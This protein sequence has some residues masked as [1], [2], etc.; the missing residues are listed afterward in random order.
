MLNSINSTFKL[1]IGILHLVT[2]QNAFI[3]I[4]LTQSPNNPK[5]RVGG[6]IQSYSTDSKT[7]TLER[8]YFVQG[9]NIEKKVKLDARE[10]LSFDV[11]TAYRTSTVK[12]WGNEQQSC[13]G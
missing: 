4:V 10:L 12:C 7:E 5:I 9:Q 11:D 3:Y 2:F 8:I 13:R 6:A 1:T